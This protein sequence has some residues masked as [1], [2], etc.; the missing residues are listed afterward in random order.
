MSVS[1]QENLNETRNLGHASGYGNY[2]T[3]G[4]QGG[5]SNGESKAY[6]LLE[7]V[8]HG[9]GGSRWM[10]PMRTSPPRP[11]LIFALRGFGELDRGLVG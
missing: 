1:F 10:P 6:M 4:P 8:I 5:N 2:G 9:S 7:R 11:T 3:Q